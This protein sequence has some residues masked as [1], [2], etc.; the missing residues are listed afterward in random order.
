MAMMMR[1]FLTALVFACVAALPARAVDFLNSI[2]DI[3]LPNGMVEASEP[4][5]FETP[6][7]RV[8]KTVALGEAD[9]SD[10]EAFYLSSLPAL[11]WRHLGED[12]IFSRRNEQLQITLKTSEDKLRV[13]FRLIARPASSLMDD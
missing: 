7:G 4:V 5:I 2:E 6:F 13:A 3:P 8:I 12:L 11:G 10:V 1:T 9:T